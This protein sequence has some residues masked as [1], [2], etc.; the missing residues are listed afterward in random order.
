MSNDYESKDLSSVIADSISLLS[1]KHSK[2]ASFSALSLET[3]GIRPPLLDI[4][5]A[6]ALNLFFLIFNLLNHHC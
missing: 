4:V 2:R 5:D 3:S 6:V 1:L